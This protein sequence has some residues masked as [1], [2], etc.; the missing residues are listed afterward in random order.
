M[1]VKTE[2]KYQLH[3]DYMFRL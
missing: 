3:Q 2:M 1:Y